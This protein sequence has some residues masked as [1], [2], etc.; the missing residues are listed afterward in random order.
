MPL[1]F[2]WIVFLYRHVALNF[3]R[4]EVVGSTKAM[5][6]PFLSQNYYKIL[7]IGIIQWIA[8]SKSRAHCILQ[9]ATAAR[10]HSCV[11]LEARALDAASNLYNV[12]TH[13]LIILIRKTR[14]W[15]PNGITGCIG[16]YIWQPWEAVTLVQRVY[17][18]V[19]AAAV[20]AE[21]ATR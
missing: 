2:S 11:F 13:F 5:I 19:A 14:K 9:V 18:L 7:R 8:F 10:R 6:R 17:T 3:C 20:L 4:I 1:F 15:F 16:L 21:L 12:T